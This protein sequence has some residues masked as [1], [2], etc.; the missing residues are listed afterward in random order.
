M[1]NHTGKLWNTR[2]QKEIKNA[3]KKSELSRQKALKR[4]GKDKQFQQNHDAEAFPQQCYPDLDLE[5]EKEKSFSRAQG[6]K[7]KPFEIMENRIEELA[8]NTK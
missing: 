5:V 3:Q 1:K 2:V 4:W 6:R 7:K 8:K